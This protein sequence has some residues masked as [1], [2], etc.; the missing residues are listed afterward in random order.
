MKNTLKKGVLVL[1]LAVLTVGGVFAQ[2]VGDTVDV[3]GQKY[4]VQEARDGRVVLQLVPTLDGTWRTGG[5]ETVT[6]NG[7]TGI[8]KQFTSDPDPL[9]KSAIDQGYFKIGDP[10]YRN[11][12]KTGDL[13]WTGE[14]KIIRYNN[15]NRNV[16]NGFGWMNVT[17]TL[18]ADGKTLYESAGA[19]F[20][21]Q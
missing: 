12:R 7:N 2:R 1:V 3:M 16:A 19:T 14:L 13:T 8:V 9:Y 6:I 4:T 10:E 17:L 5:G 15:S 21:R 18:S 11:L 20:T